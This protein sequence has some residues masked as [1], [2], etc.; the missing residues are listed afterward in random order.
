ME[1]YDTTEAALILTEYNTKY[2]Y[3]VKVCDKQW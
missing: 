1:A 3:I 2:I